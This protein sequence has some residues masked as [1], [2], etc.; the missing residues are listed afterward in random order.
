MQRGATAVASGVG[1]SGHL[2]NIPIIQVDSSR[3]L[4]NA[5]FVGSSS[6]NLNITMLVPSVSL[7][8]NQLTLST[9]N[10]IGTM[11]PSWTG[12]FIWQVVEFY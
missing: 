9:Q 10:L 6:S 11:G 2:V 5:S 1:T 8:D 3:C 7:S 12:T 4:V